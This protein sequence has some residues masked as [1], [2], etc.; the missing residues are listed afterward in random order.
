MRDL[1]AFY[2]TWASDLDE[3]R[4][5]LTEATLDETFAGIRYHFSGRHKY[6]LSCPSSIDQLK[7]I[8]DAFPLKANLSYSHPIA[9]DALKLLFADPSLAA[10]LVD[11][12]H[13]ARRIIGL[14]SF[15]SS[16]RGD[17]IFAFKVLARFVNERRFTKVA[18]REIRRL[19]SY[20]VATRALGLTLIRTNGN[21]TA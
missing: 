1:N 11:R 6:T 21:L 16:V 7:L 2:D 3:E 13:D 10:I 8:L 18:W 5:P 14:T 20:L 9:H 12:L 4:K 19:A 15:I 17:V